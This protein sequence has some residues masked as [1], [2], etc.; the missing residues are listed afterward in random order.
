M[1]G[2]V[3]GWIIGVGNDAA[4]FSTYCIMGV[5]MNIYELLSCDFIFCFGTT[6][7]I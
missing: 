7:Y 3:M 4:L 5:S 1:S 6:V 2:D